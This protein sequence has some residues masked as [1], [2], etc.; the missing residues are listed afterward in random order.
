MR[1]IKVLGNANAFGLKPAKY[2]PNP[3]VEIDELY[4]YQ[5]D[6]P[7]DGRGLV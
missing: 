4:Y 3:P 1:K 5:D 2:L 6:I 7:G